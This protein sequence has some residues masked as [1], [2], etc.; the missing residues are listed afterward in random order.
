MNNLEKAIIALQTK[1]ANNASIT[2]PNPTGYNKSSIKAAF[3]TLPKYTFSSSQP[4][5][6]PSYQMDKLKYELREERIRQGMSQ[7]DIAGRAGNS[8]TTIS[9]LERYGTSSIWGF[10]RY[11]D[12]LNKELTISNK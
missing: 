1:K 12:A 9:R 3:K 11:A 10:I 5:G 4:A 6:T 7:R 8:Q 2:T